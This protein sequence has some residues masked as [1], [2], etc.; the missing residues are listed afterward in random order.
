MYPRPKRKT[1]PIGGWTRKTLIHCCIRSAR[2]QVL[3]LR[4]RRRNAIILLEKK[5]RHARPRRPPS[6]RPFQENKPRLGRV[7]ITMHSVTRRQPP[8][9]CRWQRI[10]GCQ[11]RSAEAA[12]RRDLHHVDGCIDSLKKVP[13]TQQTIVSAN[14]RSPFSNTSFYM[15]QLFLYSRKREMLP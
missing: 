15:L 4:M 3:G 6:A 13:A 10:R 9:F 1:H 14:A 5:E 11:R 7:A 2:A 8:C 12:E